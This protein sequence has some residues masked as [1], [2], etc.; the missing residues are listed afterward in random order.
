M[1]EMSKEGEKKQ[2]VPQLAEA[3]GEPHSWVATGS[4]RTRFCCCSRAAKWVACGREQRPRLVC[5]GLGVC[6]TSFLEDSEV[7]QGFSLS[8]TKGG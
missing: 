8:K 3:N 2:F 4:L 1:F 6:L 5:F 7:K